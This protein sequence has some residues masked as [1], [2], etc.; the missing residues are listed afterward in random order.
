MLIVSALNMG[1]A[2]HERIQWKQGGAYLAKRLVSRRPTPP[3]SRRSKAPSALP[4]RSDACGM[5][6]M[7]PAA[8]PM[9]TWPAA[10]SIAIGVPKRC[11]SAAVQ[12]SSTERK[13]AVGQTHR[14][15]DMEAIGIQ[16]QPACSKRWL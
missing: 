10:A 2:S 6:A 13:H 15:V 8:P 3:A 7:P 1:C 11:S 14:N 12:S 9:H 4:R 5:H 16:S